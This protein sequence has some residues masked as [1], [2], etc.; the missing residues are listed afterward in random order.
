[1]KKQTFFLL[2]CAMLAVLLLRL[3]G[4]M[5][6][7]LDLRQITSFAMI[8][9]FT[10]KMTLKERPRAAA[11]LCGVMAVM[12]LLALLLCKAGSWCQAPTDGE[13]I[14]SALTFI[15]LAVATV[16]WLKADQAEDT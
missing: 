3:V 15:L 8:G 16:L 9:F 4:V 11:L 1:M 5:Q 12:L 7:A 13:R 6:P 10:A 2:W 14:F